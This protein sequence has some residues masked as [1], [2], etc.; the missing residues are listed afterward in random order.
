MFILF[1]QVRTLDDSNGVDVERNAFWLLGVEDDFYTIQQ[2]KVLSRHP[3]KIPGLSHFEHFLIFFSVAICLRR[4]VYPS[5]CAF[6]ASFD[7]SRFG[8]RSCPL[9]A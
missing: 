5:R 1:F 6:Y 4:R 3:R 9:H 7:R 8:R 2:I